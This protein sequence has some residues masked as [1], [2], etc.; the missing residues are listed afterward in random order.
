MEDN[1]F[2]S[3]FAN[4]CELVRSTCRTWM[5]DE[6]LKLVEE[7]D[8]VDIDGD[9]DVE[10]WNVD[11]GT[12]NG[13]RSVRLRLDKLPALAHEI[14]AQTQRTKA[15]STTTT[16]QSE[17]SPKD[18]DNYNDD[19]TTE[20]SSPWIQWDEEGW[21]YSGEGFQGTEA[22]KKERVALYLLALD[23]INFCF[24]PLP[25]SDSK[26]TNAKDAASTAPYNNPNSNNL[27]EYEHLAISMKKMAESDHGRGDGDEYVF[28][29]QN[30]ASM[31]TEKMT[32]L[33]CSCLDPLKYP[34][35]NIQKRAQLWN[36]VGES[37]LADFHGSASAL[38][39]ASKKDASKLVELVAMSFPGFRDE[40]FI[41]APS[42]LSSSPKLQEQN[43]RRIVFLKRAQIFVGDINAAL[44][45]DL[46]GMDRLT[47]FA[48]YR[49]PQIL[50]H[51]G[52]LEYSPCLASRVNEKIELE[53]GSYDE[54]SIRAS[55]VL[56]VE[57][58]VGVLNQNQTT[59]ENDQIDGSK[60]TNTTDTFTDVTVDWYLWQV[61]ERMHQ[62]GIMKPFHKVRTHFY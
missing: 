40:V 61:G 6:G 35:P 58:L 50:R 7:D 49:V 21:H 24:W 23:A 47:T 60:G 31:T 62:H 59:D 33:F 38:L 17:S 29:P 10:G 53:R 54:I 43:P 42:S 2:S 1:T 11:K 16:T 57:E 51:W 22:K 28:S 20:A 13:R 52:V 8:G 26:N 41:P 36:E 4:P 44:G 37:L 32:S 19:P 3:S 15:T 5:E 34:L 27:L 30:L 45:L 9:I 48:D 18:K 12:P 56:A 55:T 39:D 14:T 25:E 46:K